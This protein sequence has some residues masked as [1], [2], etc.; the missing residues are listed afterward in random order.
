MS[1]RAPI[2][3]GSLASWGA[4]LADQ[5][6]IRTFPYIYAGTAKLQRP[7]RFRMGCHG[8]PIEQGCHLHL[9]RPRRVWRL[10]GT[11]QVGDGQHILLECPAL[12]DARAE[13]AE[14]SPQFSGVMARLV[15][16]KDQAPVGR[17]I[18]ACLNR[19]PRG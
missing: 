7:F 2:T 17:Y 19:M 3:D 9:P 18:A 6:R 5:L 14:L 11:G 4:S 16:A 13:F 1:N 8:L 10:C 15:W 12:S